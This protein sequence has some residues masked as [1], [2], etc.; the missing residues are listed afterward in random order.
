MSCVSFPY[1]FLSESELELL[2]SGT[3]NI[4]VDEW[5]ANTQYDRFPNGDA[6]H[7]QSVVW[8]WQFVH[9]L[10]QEVCGEMI[11]VLFLD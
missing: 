5:Q 6:E 10:N 3:P 4:D 1:H 7:D 2:I 9:A 11:H 8:F